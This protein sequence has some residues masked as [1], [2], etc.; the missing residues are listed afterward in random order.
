MFPCPT[1]LTKDVKWVRLETAES[2]E[3]NISFATVELRDL[4]FDPR[5]TVLDKN[6]SHSL[7]ISNVTVD[8]SAY[9]RCVEDTGLETLHFYRLTVEGE[10]VFTAH[11]RHFYNATISKL[12]VFNFLVVTFVHRPM[13]I[14]YE[15][16]LIC[17][18]TIMLLY[19]R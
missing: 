14:N 5:F 18:V 10:S 1:E 3:T 13:T 2:T 16:V 12:L 4:G 17:F 8:D 6:H 15:R 19:P 7:V 11:T 9:Y